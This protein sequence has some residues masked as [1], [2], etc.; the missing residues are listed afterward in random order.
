MKMLRLSLI[1]PPSLEGTGT[2]DYNWLKVV[3]YDES[4]LGESQADIQTFFYCLFN[5][6]LN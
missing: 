1:S 5:F 4:W 2:R 3:W 6:I